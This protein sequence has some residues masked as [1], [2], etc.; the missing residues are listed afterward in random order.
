MWFHA[1]EKSGAGAAGA[2]ACPQSDVAAAIANA[3]V[4]RSFRDWV[5]G[6]LPFVIPSASL[7]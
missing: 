4:K 3:T 2:A 6:F 5:M 7:A 1:P